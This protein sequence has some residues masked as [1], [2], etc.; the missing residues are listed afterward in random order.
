MTALERLSIVRTD[1]FNLQL[2]PF[3]FTFNFKNA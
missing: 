3:N 2:D 1:P